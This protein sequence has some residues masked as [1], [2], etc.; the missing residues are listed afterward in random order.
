M[1][2]GYDIAP[3]Y[4]NSAENDYVRIGTTPS[5]NF[6]NGLTLCLKINFH[7]RKSERVFYSETLKLDLE[8]HR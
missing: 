1:K 5:L 8:D 7:Y 4:G 6:S 3:K 2:T